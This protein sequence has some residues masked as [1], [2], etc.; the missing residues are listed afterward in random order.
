MSKWSKVP[1]FFVRRCATKFQK[2]I[3]SLSISVYFPF[4][5]YFFNCQITPLSRNSFAADCKLAFGPEPLDTGACGDEWCLFDKKKH[6]T[7]IFILD[8]RLRFIRFFQINSPPK[9]KKEI[10]KT[11]TIIRQR[12]PN[13]TEKSKEWS[14]QHSP[15][16]HYCNSNKEKSHND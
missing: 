11:L 15:S 7:S 13:F 10:N 14:E 9:I 6:Q 1:D 3:K 12:P 16:V 2:N 4:Y 5:F 8:F